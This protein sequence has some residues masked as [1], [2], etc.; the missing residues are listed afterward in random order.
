M[1]NGLHLYS[2]FI[3]IALQYCQTFIHSFTHSPTDGGVN[4]ARG[5]PARWEQLGLGALLRD[6]STLS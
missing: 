6:T 5:Q 1:V 4:H 3:Q 2:T